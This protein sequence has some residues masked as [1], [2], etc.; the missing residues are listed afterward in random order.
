M[1]AVIQRVAR[2]SVHTPGQAPRTIGRGV[3][4]LLGVEQGDGPAD[5]A[6]MAEKI[7]HLRIF[8]GE[9][10]AAG[11]HFERSLAD[12]GGQVLLVSQFTLLGDCRRGRRP[13]FSAAARPEEAEPLYQAVAEA[14][15][16]RGLFVRTGWFGADMQVELVNEGPVTLWLD[17]RRS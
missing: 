12:V 14:L 1:R 15:A 6:W 8:P 17:S 5:V 2:A 3:V 13:S 16:A 9:G 11:R 7:A 10:E 4:V